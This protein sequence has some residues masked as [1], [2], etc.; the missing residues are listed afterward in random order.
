[1]NAEIIVVVSELYLFFAGDI[2]FTDELVQTGANPS[3]DN[4]YHI[5][6]I[7]TEDCRWKLRNTQLTVSV[8]EKWTHNKNKG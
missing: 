6:G 7:S 1:M 8:I 3:A 2:Q 5:Y 4:N